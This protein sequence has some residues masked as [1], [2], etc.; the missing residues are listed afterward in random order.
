MIMAGIVKVGANMT[1]L[2]I[3]DDQGVKEEAKQEIDVAE[4]TQ[5]DDDEDEDYND[6]DEE[7]A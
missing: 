5:Y 3:Q 1:K 2:R 4:D 7:V 6:A